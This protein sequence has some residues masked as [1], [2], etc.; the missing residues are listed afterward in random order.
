M[1]S[2]DFPL[3]LPRGSIRSI[4]ALFITIGG[5]AYLIASGAQE[6]IIAVV[7]S[8]TAFYFV[9]RQQEDRE[10]ERVADRR[11]DRNV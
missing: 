8:V 7:S 4:L 2:S 3:W 9:Q 10:A 6:A 1:F 5:G 11:E